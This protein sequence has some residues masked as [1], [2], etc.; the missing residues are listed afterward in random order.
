MKPQ[1]AHELLSLFPDGCLS[2]EGGRRLVQAPS[3]IFVQDPKV[4]VPFVS[5]PPV[6]R[7]QEVTKHSKGNVQ[8]L[9]GDRIGVH[10]GLVVEVLLCALASSPT[11]V[12]HSHSFSHRIRGRGRGRRKKRL[13]SSD[14]PRMKAVEENDISVGETLH[15]QQ[16]REIGKVVKKEQFGRRD[17]DGSHQEA[18][19][20][21]RS[22]TRQQ[23]LSEPQ[24]GP[25]FHASI[26]G[27]RKIN[28]TNLNRGH[29]G[30]PSWSECRFEDHHVAQRKVSVHTTK[31]FHG[32]PQ[33]C[34]QLSGS[35]R[36]QVVFSSV[37]RWLL[38]RGLCSGHSRQKVLMHGN[39][40][41]GG[42]ET[43]MIQVSVRFAKQLGLKWGREKLPRAKS[44]GKREKTRTQR[45]GV[46]ISLFCRFGCFSQGGRSF[47]TSN[48]MHG[49]SSLESIC[50]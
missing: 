7:I 48:Q 11:Q 30:V 36:E 20:V 43:K 2:H 27:L 39:P 50:S 26:Q 45:P 33:T 46:G 24:E 18:L 16:V 34:Q 49:K 9:K 44:R 40:G 10:R 35:Q 15:A 3:V 14:P 8:H 12:F 38:G 23:T 29:G 42:V 6:V 41:E 17:V 31:F 19:F 32:F 25:F 22:G 37:V 21:P 13:R 5:C 47:R 1:G 4:L 28:E